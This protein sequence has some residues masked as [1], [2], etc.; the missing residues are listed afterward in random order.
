MVGYRSMT[1]I[2]DDFKGE[3]VGGHR[4]LYVSRACAQDQLKRVNLSRHEEYIR[5]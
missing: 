1:C 5:T 2:I 4:I 3:S